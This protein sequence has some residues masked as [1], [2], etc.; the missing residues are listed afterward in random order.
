ML[1]PLEEFRSVIHILPARYS[2]FRCVRETCEKSSPP[3]DT[4]FSLPRPTVKEAKGTSNQRTGPLLASMT[5]R[6]RSPAAVSASTGLLSA[7][8]ALP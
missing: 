2:T 6:W 3:S 1:V 4:W 7:L 5:T 8:S